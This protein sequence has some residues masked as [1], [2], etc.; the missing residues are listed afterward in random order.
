VISRVSDEA[1]AIRVDL[2]LI[3]STSSVGRALVAPPDNDKTRTAARRAAFDRMAK[4]AEFLADAK[5]QNL[6]ISP[7]GGI[8]A[9]QL[10]AKMIAASPAIIEKA[11]LA[12]KE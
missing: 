7:V 1:A 9:E 4:D 5:K 10:V 8:E 12:T 6:P 3:S 2:R 11:L